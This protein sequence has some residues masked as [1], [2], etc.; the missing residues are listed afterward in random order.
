L[1]ANQK[2]PWIARP[3]LMV[4]IGVLKASLLYSINAYNFKQLRRKVDCEVDALHSL[5]VTRD[6]LAEFTDRHR[7][8]ATYGYAYTFAAL[9]VQP[10]ST[11][12][13]HI[14]RL[15]ISLS[16]LWPSTGCHRQSETWCPIWWA[17]WHRS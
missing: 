7:L 8:Q 17:R 5:E 15:S 13:A 14:A 12:H 3:D 9:S 16:L 10:A 11:D 6:K 2:E 4:E 1:L